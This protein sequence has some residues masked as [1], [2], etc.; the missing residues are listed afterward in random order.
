MSAKR[1]AHF[2]S[3]LT[4]CC[5]LVA[6]ALVFKSELPA[7][8]SSLNAKLT[9]VLTAC[10]SVRTSERLRE[11]LQLILQVRRFDCRSVDCSHLVVAAA[12]QQD[13]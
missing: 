6:G 3:L 10:Q 11:V 7:T 5:V 8:I 2:S 1:C 12:G 13:E 9:S 4:I